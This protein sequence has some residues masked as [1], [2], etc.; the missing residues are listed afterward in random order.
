MVRSEALPT[1]ALMV[2]SEALPT[3]ALMVRSEALP[4]EAL[5]VRS[6]ALPT[7]ALMV[8]IRHQPGAD[9][10]LPADLGCLQRNL[11]PLLARVPT[12]LLRPLPGQEDIGP[13][14]PVPSV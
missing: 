2:R 3:E 13:K 5:M 4:T 6:E 7:E 1:E 14:F 10:D 9:Q 12:G 11:V 8:P